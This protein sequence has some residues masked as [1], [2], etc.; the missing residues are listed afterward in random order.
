MEWISINIISRHFIFD[1]QEKQIESMEFLVHQNVASQNSVTGKVESG[2]LMSQLL[3][4]PRFSGRAL[5]TLML[6]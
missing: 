2:D 4:N 5:L 1:L 6:W 3:A